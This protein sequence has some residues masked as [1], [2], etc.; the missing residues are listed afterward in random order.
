MAVWSP[1]ISNLVLQ[2]NSFCVLWDTQK[3]EGFKDSVFRRYICFSVYVITE[4]LPFLFYTIFCFY[5]RWLAPDYSWKCCSPIQSIM[6]NTDGTAKRAKHVIVLW[7][8][9]VYIKRQIVNVST[10]KLVFVFLYKHQD[11]T[12][13]LHAWLSLLFHLCSS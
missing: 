8:L 11:F 5:V 2:N 1:R 10:K 4:A 9:G 6:K 3:Y 12:R 13:V 7:S